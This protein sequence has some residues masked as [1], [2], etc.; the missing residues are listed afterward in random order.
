METIKDQLIDVIDQT[1]DYSHSDIKATNI[2]YHEPIRLVFIQINRCY[3]CNKLPVDDINCLNLGRLYGWLYCN[4]CTNDVKLSALH[5]INNNNIPLNWLFSSDK[6][7]NPGDSYSKKLHFFRY[8]K[9][10][11]P[12]EIQD[13]IIRYL[14]MDEYDYGCYMIQKFESMPD[15]KYGVHLC[16]DDMQRNEKQARIVSLANIFAH[17]KNLYEELVNCKNI[18]D[19]TKIVIGFDE[20]SLELKYGI[21]D[22]YKLSCTKDKHSYNK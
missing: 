2:K 20:L 10:D 16:F 3:I 11:T 17:T 8:S 6:F 7:N 13:A 22:A 9:K 14:D 12:Y 15:N 19:D 18:F 21:H 4:D 1:I 5:F